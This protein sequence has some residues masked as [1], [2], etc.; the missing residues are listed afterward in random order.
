MFLTDD[1]LL[2]ILHPVIMNITKKRIGRRQNWSRIHAQMVIYFCRTYVRVTLLVPD[3]KGRISGSVALD[4]PY[5]RYVDEK[6]ATGFL[7]YSPE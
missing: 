1:N 2:K 3:V 6:A 5:L 4:M 7:D